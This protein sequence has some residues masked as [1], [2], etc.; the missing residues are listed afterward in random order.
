MEYPQFLVIDASSYELDGH[1]IAIAWSLTDGTIKSTLLQPEE[2]WHEWDIGLEDLHGM[3]QEILIQSGEPVWEAVKEFEFDCEN[4]IYLVQ[5]GERT[6][7]LLERMYD[8]YDK[9]PGA[10]LIGIHEWHP[11]ET[12]ERY[13]LM[14]DIRSDLELSPYRCEDNVRL[15]LEMWVRVNDAEQRSPAND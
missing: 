10:D 14:E 4:S 2:N 13:Q 5:D 3:T 7:E 11:S 6:M 12:E 9:E 15:M 8:A 1:P